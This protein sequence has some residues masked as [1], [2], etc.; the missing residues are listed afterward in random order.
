MSQFAN[1]LAGLI[2]KPVVDESGLKGFFDFDV[3]SAYGDIASALR[4]QLGLTL[5][6]KDGTATVLVIQFARPPS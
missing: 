6:A 5:L 1:A 2:G 4:E 3:F